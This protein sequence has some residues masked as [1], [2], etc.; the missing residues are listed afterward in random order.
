M[1]SYL[2]GKHKL[3]PF[4]AVFPRMRSWA[5]TISGIS[6]LYSE[7]SGSN[8]APR[9]FYGASMARYESGVTHI[10]KGEDGEAV[11]AALLKEINK[12]IGSLSA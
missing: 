1:A 9:V 6:F 3:Q 12:A 2:I 11:R 7:D 5:A 10:A 4:P 8:V